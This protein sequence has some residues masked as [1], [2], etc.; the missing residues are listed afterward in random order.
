M[1]IE[2]ERCV[3]HKPNLDNIEEGK[4]FMA[5]HGKTVYMRLKPYGLP[6]LSN[7]PDIAVANLSNGYVYYWNRHKE[8]V[9][10]DARVVVT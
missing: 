8:V 1:E 2:F 7:S 5:V 3:M 4:C 6:L 10:V 9:P